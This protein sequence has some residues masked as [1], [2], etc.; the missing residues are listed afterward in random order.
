LWVLAD[1][2]THIGV[3]VEPDATPEQQRLWNTNR[4]TVEDG[5]AV[6]WLA[7][8]RAERWSRKPAVLFHAIWISRE[9]IPRND[10]NHVPTSLEAW[11]HRV[12]RWRRGAVALSHYF[13]VRARHHLHVRARNQ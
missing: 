5:A 1:V 11:R 2:L 7:A 6:S 9:D 8:M 12:F 13:G 4:A 10:P 3:I